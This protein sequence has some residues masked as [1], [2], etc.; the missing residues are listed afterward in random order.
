MNLITDQLLKKMKKTLILALIMIG[1]QINAQERKNDVMI[2]PIHLIAEPSIN[3]Y[4]ERI[5]NKEN[6]VGINLII[7]GEDTN[8]EFSP[9]Y[10]MYFGK[11]YAQGFF[12]EGFLPITNAGYEE[13]TTKKKYVL[14]D[15]N[16]EYSTYIVDCNI[17]NLT[18]IGVGFG[19]G[20]KFVVKRNIVFE[21]SA[22]M[23][24]RFGINN[25]YGSV[26]GKGMLGIGY[27]F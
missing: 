9:F 23:L 13:C 18:T 21:V 14:D 8:Y 2:S 3:V 12:I 17:R 10:R 11:K 27:R 4:Y 24:R 5:L 19:G 22:G 16:T 15:N 6:G 1:L 26:S 25:N 7:G 20:F